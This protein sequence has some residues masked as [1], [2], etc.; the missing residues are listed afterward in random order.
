MKRWIEKMSDKDLIREGAHELAISL[1]QKQ[2]DQ[3]KEYKD[4]LLE[5]NKSMNLTAITEDREFIIKHFFDSFT[6]TRVYDFKRVDSILDIGTGAGL[7]GMV[8][9]I[10]YPQISFVLVDSL[11]KR[12]EFLKDVVESLHLEKIKCI[13]GRAE[14]L[15]Q[16]PFYRESFDIVVSRAVANLAVLSEYCLPFVN[17]NRCFLCLKGPK[18]KEELKESQGA[19]TKLGGKLEKIEKIKVP[20]SDITHYILR[21]RKIKHTPTKYPRKP[22]KPTKNPIK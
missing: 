16:D 6:L 15:G 2:L 11:N 18:Y 1:T 19:I 10:L 17:V 9:K 21:I 8:L 4:I 20:F 3:L 22:G 13:H 12:I 14:K 7:P 5:V